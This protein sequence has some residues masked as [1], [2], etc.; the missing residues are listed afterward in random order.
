MDV[1]N[2]YDIYDPNTPKPTTIDMLDYGMKVESGLIHIIKTS[3]LD[4]ICIE[5]E[6]S[7]Y[8]ECD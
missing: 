1:F 5:E 4:E 6:G 3:F 7:W 8:C 2:D